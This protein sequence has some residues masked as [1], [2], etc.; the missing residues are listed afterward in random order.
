MAAAVYGLVW[1]EYGEEDCVGSPICDWLN[2]S[3]DVWA[4]VDV[5]TANE[6]FNAAIE[7]KGS[8]VWV[9]NEFAGIVELVGEVILQGNDNGVL[10]IE[11]SVV[12]CAPSGIFPAQPVY[13]YSGYS[14]GSYW[15]IGKPNGPFLISFIW[16]RSRLRHLA[17]RFL[18]HTLNSKVIK[19][20]KLLSQVVHYVDLYPS[21]FLIFLF[22][23]GEFRPTIKYFSLH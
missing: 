12:L 16:F 13:E 20:F 17:R 5:W 10:P 4:A 8:P 15:P 21:I 11:P 2:L 9:E 6:L 22:V 7:L 1:V 3:H 18:N 23:G 14:D 19:R